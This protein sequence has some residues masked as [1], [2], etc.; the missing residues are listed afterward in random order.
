MVLHRDAFRL[1]IA[2]RLADGPGDLN[3]IRCQFYGGG[4]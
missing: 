3:G 4:L 1:D 2:V